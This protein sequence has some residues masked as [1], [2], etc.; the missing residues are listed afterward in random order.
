MRQAPD[1]RRNPGTSL[2]AAEGVRLDELIGDAEP[3]DLRCAIRDALGIRDKWPGPAEF[4]DLMRRAVVSVDGE[5]L[6]NASERSEAAYD[7]S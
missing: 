5:T 1:F 7:R 6:L 3:D 4:R 2:S